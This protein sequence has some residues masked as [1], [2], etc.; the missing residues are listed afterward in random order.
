MLSQ[1]FSFKLFRSKIIKKKRR[2]SLSVWI[3][4]PYHF[5]V[6]P[7][8]GFDV[9]FDK[10]D[11]IFLCQCTLLCTDD[12]HVMWDYTQYLGVS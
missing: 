3:I 9:V 12:V 1:I 7:E 10:V 11:P 8:T 5:H 6:C 2:N 4:S